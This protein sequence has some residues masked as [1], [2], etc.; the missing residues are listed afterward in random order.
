MAITLET[1]LVTAEQILAY[2]SKGMEAIT[3]AAGVVKYSELE[4]QEIMNTV[5]QFIVGNAPST[6]D[7]DIQKFAIKTLCKEELNNRMYEDGIL[8]DWEPVDVFDKDYV[9]E[10]LTKIEAGEDPTSHMFIF[11]NT[12]EN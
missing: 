3:N 11:N 10:M 9:V 4:L 8:L 5:I 2:Q 7:E 12:T 6:A 1:T